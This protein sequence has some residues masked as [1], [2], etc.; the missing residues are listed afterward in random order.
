M[1]AQ[2]IYHYLEILIF[3]LVHEF[4]K[5]SLE[6]YYYYYYYYYLFIVDQ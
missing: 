5:S 6:H 4:G 3:H 1:E 2:A